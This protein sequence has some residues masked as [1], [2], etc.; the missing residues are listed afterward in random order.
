M[1]IGCVFPLMCCYGEANAPLIVVQQSVACVA[2]REACARLAC[3]SFRPRADIVENKLKRTWSMQT[4]DRCMPVTQSVL[5]VWL[6]CGCG[7]D[8]MRVGARVRCDKEV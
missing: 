3:A 8:V 6:W 4:P 7:I 1:P 2:W 5:V